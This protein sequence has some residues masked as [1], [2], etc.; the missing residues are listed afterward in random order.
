M[1]ATVSRIRDVVTNSSNLLRS[2]RVRT[3]RQTWP[4]PCLKRM[5]LS[6]YSEKTVQQ[7]TGSIL[8]VAGVLRVKHDAAHLKVI[9]TI[10]HTPIQAKH[11]VCISFDKDG[12]ILQTLNHLVFAFEEFPDTRVNSIYL[13]SVSRD[14]DF[15]SRIGRDA[16]SVGDMDC[17][18]KDLKA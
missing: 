14:S 4:L 6:L 5:R 3:E 8:H 12:T 9:K 1:T 11:P 7:F 10:S 15:G 13:N 17:M 18:S 16:E 2:Q